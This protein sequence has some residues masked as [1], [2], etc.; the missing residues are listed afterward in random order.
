MCNGQTVYFLMSALGVLIKWSNIHVIT[1]Y[2]IYKNAIWWTALNAI[3]ITLANHTSLV[4]SASPQGCYYWLLLAIKSHQ[5]FF[6]V[7]NKQQMVRGSLMAVTL[8]I[9][10]YTHKHVTEVQSHRG[11]IRDRRNKMSE[12]KRNMSAASDGGPSQSLLA[13]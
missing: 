9:A 8:V 10:K 12:Y 6:S 3:F 11:L 7:P 13:L 5:S 1:W 2:Q 4:K